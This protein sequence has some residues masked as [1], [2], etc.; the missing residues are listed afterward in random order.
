MTKP[1]NKVIIFI[2]ECLLFAGVFLASEIIPSLLGSAVLAGV[3]AATHGGSI[4]SEAIGVWGP[5]AIMAAV[6]YLLT[7]AMVLLLAR[8]IQK[9]KPAS[10]GFVKEHALRDFGIGIAVGAVM[11][12]S[13]IGICL[14]T[15]A[16]SLQA[17]ASL[18]IKLLLIAL[19]GWVFQ[20]F[21][22]E[23]LCRGF[24]MGS[25]TR[26]FSVP[27]AVIVNSLAFAVPHLGNSGI[28]V[29]PVINIILFGICA[30]LLYYKTGS[31][32]L[33][34]A[35][36]SAWNALQG[37][38]FGIAVSGTEAQNSTVLTATLDSSK[39]LI[40]GGTFG[41]EGG[42]ATTVVLVITNVIILLWIF[43]STTK[44]QES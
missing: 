8:L 1:K 38:V 31:I 5:T 40:N 36:H 18:D 17:V 9:R 34:G 6:I 23:T 42:I 21:S 3:Y 41:A 32:W 24:F 14:L 15:G 27:L 12:T 37:N 2:L 25:L 28:G 44:K 29:L 10:L 43:R 4:D 39:S 33:V 11:F 13:V 7:T 30:S 35:M 22:E 19:L 20:S 16:V 26:N